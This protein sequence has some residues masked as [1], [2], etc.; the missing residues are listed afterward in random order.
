[1]VFLVVGGG[2]LFIGSV[3]SARSS[4]GRVADVLDQEVD[5]GQEEGCHWEE[6]GG[7]HGLGLVERGSFARVVVETRM[8]RTTGLM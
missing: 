6:C 5:E 3:I 8:S 4:A 7:G 2:D 1:M